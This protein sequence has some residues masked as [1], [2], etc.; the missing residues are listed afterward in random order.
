[1]CDSESCLGVPSPRFRLGQ[2]V[3]TTGIYDDTGEPY[4]HEGTIL[5]FAYN[6]FDR[7]GWSYVVHF[8]IPTEL[9]DHLQEDSLEATP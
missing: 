8:T 9:F 3:T 4:Q 7:S 1:M 5:G 6:L 2:R